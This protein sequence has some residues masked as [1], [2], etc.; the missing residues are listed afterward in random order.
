MLVKLVLICEFCI[1]CKLKIL[2]GKKGEGKWKGGWGRGMSTFL[3][4]HILIPARTSQKMQNA[5]NSKSEKISQSHIIIE[6]FR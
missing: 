5:K 3:L 6:L 2:A 4:A 1:F